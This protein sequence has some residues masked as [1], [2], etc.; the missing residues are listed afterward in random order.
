[1]VWM[2][3]VLHGL[4]PSVAMMEG[5]GT[6]K[7]WGPVGGNQ[8][9]RTKP[10]HRINAGKQPVRADC[11]PLNFSGFW[12][13]QVMFLLP[14][15]TTMMQRIRGQQMLVTQSYNSKTLS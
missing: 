2:W 8:I 15:T 11:F 6:F 10:M 12:P 1:M 13:S 5:G 4:I 3:F 9:I 7:R 14:Y